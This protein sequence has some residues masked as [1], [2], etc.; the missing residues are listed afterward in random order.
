MDK[1]SL[2]YFVNSQGKKTVLSSPGNRNYWELR[3]RRGFAAPEID[4]FTQKF[5]SG[6]VKFFGK[7]L[8]PRTCSLQMICKGKD[9]AEM[10]RV[11]FGML[12]TLIDNGSDQEGKLCL[13]RSDGTPVYLNCVYSG[14]M[15]VEE[16]YRRF[17][18]FSVEFY[19]ADPLFYSDKVYT[20]DDD[21]SYKVLEINNE[22]GQKIWP[23]FHF[24]AKPVRTEDQTSF[25]RMDYAVWLEILRNP[26]YQ[27]SHPQ[28]YNI[29][30]Y[31]DPVRRGVFG[32]RAGG[33]V[34]QKNVSIPEILDDP[35]VLRSF[36]C[37][38]GISHLDYAG[39]EWT[40]GTPGGTII[41]P[42]CKYYLGA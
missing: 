40:Y 5:A 25:F 19:A 7:T 31:T 4:P 14:G 17:R 23:E 1:N 37:D 34:L 35:N 28:Y 15:N 20:I 39:M 30:I 33:G 18:S 12:E 8:K 41:L 3:G 10:D 42:K 9:T 29:S 24:Y 36:Y 11:F 21:E 27:G 26:E 32:D 6:K 38:E 22:S 13:K 16:Q 2:V